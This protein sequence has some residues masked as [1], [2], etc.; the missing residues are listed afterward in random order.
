MN[1]AA[2]EATVQAYCRELTTPTLY[3][4]HTTLARQ[5]RDDGWD[6]E[7]FLVQLLEVEIQTRRAHTIARRLREA[8]FPDVKA[9][10]QI[11]WSALKGLSRPKLNE[12]AACDYIDQ[13][14]D[15]VLAGPIGTGKTQVSIPLSVEA[16]R[17]RYVGEEESI[18]LQLLRCRLRA[19]PETRLSFGCM[20]SERG[21]A[22]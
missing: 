2:R 10:D 20:R 14:D 13:A 4:G 12:L 15:I 9:F 19:H 8:N 17:R 7:E 3:R 1:I 22:E 6:Y 11:E 18:P 16:A 5:A 21:F